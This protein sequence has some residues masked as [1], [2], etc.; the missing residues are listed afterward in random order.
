[1][2]LPKVKIVKAW[3]CLFLAMAVSGHASGNVRAGIAMDADSIDV[4]LDKALEIALSES[5]SIVIADKQIEIKKYYS[6]EQIAALIPNLS[7]SASYSRSLK[8]QMISIGGMEPIQMGTDN[9][10]N[11]GFNLSVP[12]IAPALWNTVRL[13]KLDI[14]LAVETAR[15]SRLDMANQV[16]KAFYQLLLARESYQ[17]L[18]M[19]YENMK[20][21]LKNV[22][23]KFEQGTVSEYDKIRTEVQLQNI[24]PQIVS[25]KN[26]VCLADLQLKILIGVDVSEPVK[27][28]G[29]IRQYEQLLD[30][31]AMAALA[32][33]IYSDT[34]ALLDNNT[35][36]RQIRI[37]EEQ[38]ARTASVLKSQYSPTLALS[39]NY[40]WMTMN[41]DFKI[42]SYMWYP[43][44]AV[45]LTLSVPIFQGTKVM[46]QVRQNR[47]QR[48]NLVIQ[49]EDLVR[50]TKIAVQ[51]AINNM[52]TA[53]EEISYSRENIKQAEKAFEISEERYAIGA[54]TLLEVNDADL[55]LTQS[56]LSYSQSIYNYLVAYADL[57]KVL[58][59]EY[60]A[61]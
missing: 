15:S 46:N 11:A 8:K 19:S 39:A 60:H 28:I 17:V 50:Q 49:R 52:N 23:D 5:P 44:S 21:N 29:D 35:Q 38:L 3:I 27:F 36:L 13:S 37:Q 4:D 30:D 2:V 41:N 58:G 45:G 7:A 42:G 54:G 32:L 33:E 10:Y 31:K 43:N 26:N 14:E 25:A 24:K 22:L 18:V 48:E 9:T 51:T 53:V 57:Q 56:R 12:V 40:G 61:E 16:R 6:K 34:T 1:M 20:D 47:L 55:A 59:I